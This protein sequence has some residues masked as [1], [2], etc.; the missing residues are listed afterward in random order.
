M[1]SIFT[2]MGGNRRAV[3]TNFRLTPKDVAVRVSTGAERECRLAG[4]SNIPYDYV[5]PPENLELTTIPFKW[6]SDEEWSRMPN[7]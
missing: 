1:D 2:P 5:P 6:P 4:A 7:W 3:Q